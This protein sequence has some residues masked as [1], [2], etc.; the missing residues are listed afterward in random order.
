VLNPF[1]KKR[2]VTILLIGETGSGK[3]SL[4]SLLVN[5]F[6]GQGPLELSEKNDESKE[7]GLSKSQSQ[8]TK[9]TL[10]TVTTSDGTKIKLL[11]TPGLADTCGIEVDNKHKAEINNAIKKYITSIDAVI[12]LANGTVERLGAATEYTLSVITSMFP[13]S[14]IENIGFVF[15]NSDILTWNFKMDSLQPELRKS[16]Y[17][18]I[19]NP[20]ALHKNYKKVEEDNGAGPLLN[21]MRLK[22]EGTYTEAVM[23]LNDLLGWLDDC[24]TQ[25]TKEIDHLYQMS[26]GIE[27]N[28]E[29]TLTALT[30][31]SEQQH[32]WKSIE[33]NLQNTEKASIR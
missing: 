26:V 20:L 33:F 21:A 9:A 10:Y 31:L 1:K 30:R 11:D 2:E 19:Q 29:A 7:S 14:I 17:W 28:I 32:K 5:L 3:T 13:R 25:P 23:I 8:T 22:L 6:Q 24:D 27:A 18:L 12:I 15:T 16:R 4:M